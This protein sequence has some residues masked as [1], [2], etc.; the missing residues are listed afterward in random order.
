LLPYVRATLRQKVRRAIW[1]VDGLWV[2]GS[3][4]KHT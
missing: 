1:W 2:A 4:A 3:R